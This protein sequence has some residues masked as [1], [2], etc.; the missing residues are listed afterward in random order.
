MCEGLDSA[1]IWGDPSGPSQRYQP[2]G[3]WLGFNKYI[4]LFW[5][6]DW[7]HIPHTRTFNTHPFPSWGNKLNRSKKP[8]PILQ[9][10]NP[11]PDFQGNI[12]K[13]ILIDILKRLIILNLTPKSNLNSTSNFQFK[14]LIRREILRNSKNTLLKAVL[15]KTQDAIIIWLKSFLLDNFEEDAE[16]TEENLP[17]VPLEAYN[18]SISF[19]IDF[20]VHIPIII[21]I[22]KF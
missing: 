7:N 8:Y 14:I 20:T 19:S 22:I 18:I 3:R 12:K 5:W 10:S 16:M 15:I 1:Q 17:L 4:I 9:F 13:K 11:D 21:V 2:I 6:E